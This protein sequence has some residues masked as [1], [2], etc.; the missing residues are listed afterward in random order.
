[1]TE[2]GLPETF[3]QPFA[4]LQGEGR[5]RGGPGRRDSTAS[6]RG[7]VRSRGN[8]AS[9]RGQSQIYLSYAEREQRKTAEGGL[10][11]VC[12]FLS[13]YSTEIPTLHFEMLLPSAVSVPVFQTDHGLQSVRL[14]TPSASLGFARNDAGP[15]GFGMVGRNRLRMLP[16]CAFS[17][18]VLQT[19]HGLRS[20]RLGTPKAFLG[21][22]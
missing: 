15:W 18:P 16:P 10:I 11:S 22:E 2:T 3:G 4:S 12:S 6:F 8:V 13:L 17:V 9:K 19:D 5:F 14:G 1:M 7:F 20:V 21:S